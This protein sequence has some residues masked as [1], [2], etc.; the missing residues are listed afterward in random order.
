MPASCKDMPHRSDMTPDGANAWCVQATTTPSD[1]VEVRTK[2]AS[3]A[4]ML[5][6][7]VVT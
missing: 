2:G 7:V 6:D 5:M 4:I 1:K 3:S